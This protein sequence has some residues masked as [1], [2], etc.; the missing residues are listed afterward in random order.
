MGRFA[1]EFGIVAY[2]G[3]SNN[4]TCGN[5]TVITSAHKPPYLT[6]GEVDMIYLNACKLQ[7]G[8]DGVETIVSAWEEHMGLLSSS[9]ALR[10]GKNKHVPFNVRHSSDVIGGPSGNE[11]RSI[12]GRGHLSVHQLSISQFVTCM[13]SVATRLYSTLIEQQTGTILE[14][15]PPRQKESATSA[16]L[17]VLLK[18]KILPVAEALG[19]LP[20]PLIYLDQTLTSINNSI[21]INNVLYSKLDM[22]IDLFRKYSTDITLSLPINIGSSH[23]QLLDEVIDAIQSPTQKLNLSRKSNSNSPTKLIHHNP[24]YQN[25]QIVVQGINY[26]LLSKLAHDYG[27]IPNLIKEGDF[28]S[29]FEEIVLW[30]RTDLHLMASALSD[31]IIQKSTLFQEEIEW[32]KTA[33]KIRQLTKKIIAQSSTTLSSTTTTTTTYANTNANTNTQK[34]LVYG[35]SQFPNQQV[36]QILGL[37]SFI[38]LLSAIGIQ[39]SNFCCIIL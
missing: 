30:C 2:T 10:N 37:A 31:N 20:W 28:F 39:V 33:E 18:R 13:R 11:A 23:Q 29:Q 1:K 25:K 19:L 24:H 21:N 34:S 4:T 5:N 36:T 6:S 35:P 12:N 32:R 7:D 22:V 26:K 3:A 8:E 16:A 38:I 27:I 17:E 9:S 15:L 14:C